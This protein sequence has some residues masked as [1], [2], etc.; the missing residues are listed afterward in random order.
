MEMFLS[1]KH[2]QKMKKEELTTFERELLNKMNI[3]S[4]LIIQIEDALKEIKLPMD[5]NIL[6]QMNTE[7]LTEFLEMVERMKENRKKI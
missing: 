5:K 1:K 2:L 3:Q 7:D 4:M 6:Y